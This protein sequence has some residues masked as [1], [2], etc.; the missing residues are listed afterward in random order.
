MSGQAATQVRSIT[1]KR[2]RLA[3]VKSYVVMVSIEDMATVLTLKLLSPFL[4]E[5]Y[6]YHYTMLRGSGLTISH[7][8]K[9]VMLYNVMSRIYV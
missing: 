2:R 6:I 4:L 7:F 5:L 3:T 1:I 9:L 8:E